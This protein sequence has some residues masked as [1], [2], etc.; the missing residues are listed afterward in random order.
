MSKSR[1]TTL[2]A[3][4]S[5]LLVL[6]LTAG[7]ET[8]AAPPIIDTHTH[9]DVAS[10]L[11]GSVEAAIQNMDQHGIRRIILMSPPRAPGG[12]KG[13]YEA[14]DLR[15]AMEKYPGRVALSGGGGSLNA[16]IHETP[17][18]SVSE[19]AKERFRAQAEKIAQMGVVGFGEI[20]IHHLS[21]KIM[22][23]RHPY[24]RVPP[25]HPLLLVLA[26]VAAAKGIP[27]DVHMDL[28]PEDMDL[29]SRPVFNAANPSRLKGNLLAF[30]RL[31]DHNP[32]ANI[33]WAHAGTD[34]LGT[35]FPPVQRNLLARHP[36]LY[37]SLRLGRGAPPP[38]FA[39]NED[40]TLKPAWRALLAD[41]P[42]RFVLG[43]DTFFS[44]AGRL[45]GPGDAGLGNLSELLKQLPPELAEA[46]AHVNAERL[47]HLPSI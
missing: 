16:A 32:A 3:A 37:M 35:R 47:Y 19:S 17:A 6:A 20:A 2:S 7:R 15:F 38:V 39:L 44:A 1:T 5:A 10:S 42:T 22:G 11:G 27:L 23:P 24:E 43:S 8:A 21:L 26:D 14:D 36:N 18:E 31:L 28:V 25:D 40:L 33:V 4:Y 41:F 29:P 46:I 12:A 30:E 9:L 13:V 45:R 34:P